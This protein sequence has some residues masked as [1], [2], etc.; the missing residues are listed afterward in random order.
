MGSALQSYFSPLQ[1]FFSKEMLS[2]TFLD[3][4]LFSATDNMKGS[5]VVLSLITIII[6]HNIPDTNTKASQSLLLLQT[7]THTHTDYY[8]HPHWSRIYQQ[9]QQPQLSEIQLHWKSDYLSVPGKTFCEGWFGHW[10]QSE[11]H[12]MLMFSIKPTTRDY[13]HS[14]DR[15]EKSRWRLRSLARWLLWSIWI[16]SLTFLRTFQPQFSHSCT[17]LSKPN[18]L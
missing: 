4:I 7:Q 15:Q 2:K 1:T 3:S 5:V 8:S 14:S 16:R 12:Q 17:P 13:S 11:I 9:Q 6:K 18:N 10:R